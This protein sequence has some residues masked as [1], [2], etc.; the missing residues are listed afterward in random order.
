MRL[1]S[2]SANAWIDDSVVIASAMS[3]RPGDIGL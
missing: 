3:G 2:R 1:G